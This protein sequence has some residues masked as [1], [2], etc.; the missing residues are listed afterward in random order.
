MIGGPKSLKREIVGLK[1]DMTDKALD[2]EALRA[3]PGGYR[4]DNGVGFTKPDRSSWWRF[5]FFCLDPRAEEAA[6]ASLRKSTIA[7]PGTV[8][9]PTNATIIDP[10]NGIA[11]EARLEANRNVEQRVSVIDI[12]LSRQ[13]S[14]AAGRNLIEPAGPWHGTEPFSMIAS[15]L[16]SGATSM[17]GMRRQIPIQ[18][19]NASLIINI[20]KAEVADCAVQ[21]TCSFS[22]VVVEVSIQH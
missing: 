3:C 16:K 15:D 9:S 1:S 12:I 8:A 14:G 11:Y 22:N 19:T 7:L 6:R 18:G 17:F 21:A 13:G 4:S 20:K 10:R 2:S 5:T